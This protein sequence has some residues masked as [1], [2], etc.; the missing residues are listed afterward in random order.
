MEMLI[1]NLS[2]VADTIPNSP[3]GHQLPTQ[4]KKNV[5]IIDING[6]KPTTAQGAL[7]EL[8][9]NQ[10]PRVKSKVNI[11]ICIN[12]IYQSIYIEN[13]R[14]IFDQVRPV[15]SNLEYHL[16]DKSLTPKKIGEGLKVFKRQLCK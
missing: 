5:C 9:H 13:I 16:P 1:W 11:S 6:E 14:S 12:K 3:D 2:Y 10:N 15:V 4:A 8:N 7:D